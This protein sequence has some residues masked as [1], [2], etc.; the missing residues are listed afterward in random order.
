[1]NNKLTRSLRFVSAV[2]FAIVVG[3]PESPA[4]AGPSSGGCTKIGVLPTDLTCITV[5]GEGLRVDGV[6]GRFDKVGGSLCNWRYEIAFSDLAGKVYRVHKGP[7]HKS[8][9]LGGEYT[10]SYPSPITRLPGKV[11]ARLYENGSFFDA[12]CVSLT[13]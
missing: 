11:C 8:C 6:K 3:I 12:A 1:M 4:Y 10:P 9:D 13:P 5:Y 2:A 7:T